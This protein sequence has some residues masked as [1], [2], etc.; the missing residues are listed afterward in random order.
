MTHES[1]ANAI[2]TRFKTQIADAQSL[3]TQYDNQK[4][5][6]PD[7]V[8]WCRL[9]IKFGESLQVASG[10]AS[11]NRY[12]TSGIMYAQ[13]FSPLGKGDK[14]QLH[15]ADIIKSAFRCVTDSGVKFKTP[16]IKPKGR[17]GKEWQVNIECPF[18][19][20]DTG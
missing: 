17:F 4:Y 2:R 16:S 20:D 15:L 7:N 9:T 19:A 12:R 5:D 6:N 13:L 11:G 10:G 3:P 1:M 18:Y 14:D 8:L